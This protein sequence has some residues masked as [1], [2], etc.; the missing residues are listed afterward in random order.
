M[1]WWRGPGIQQMHLSTPQPPLQPGQVTP[2]G[3]TYTGPFGWGWINPQGIAWAFLS[4]TFRRQQTRSHQATKG[5]QG[6][7]P[8]DHIQWHVSQCKPG[9]QS[10]ERHRSHFSLPPAAPQP[11]STG[12]PWLPHPAVV[13]PLPSMFKPISRLLQRW[14]TAPSWPGPD[15]SKAHRPQRVQGSAVGH[16]HGSTPKPRRESETPGPQGECGQPARITLPFGTTAVK[17]GERV[18]QASL[19]E[20]EAMIPPNGAALYLSLLSPPPILHSQVHTPCTQLSH[21]HTHTHVITLP[22]PQLHNYSFPSCHP[23]LGTTG[24]SAPGEASH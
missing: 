10:S 19:P 7:A 16:R 15:L 24:F 14:V 17:A 12:H 18:V 11:W 3:R 20:P 22:T 1:C 4:W 9:W 6:M 21:T 5:P 2:A 13:L 8:G 23:R